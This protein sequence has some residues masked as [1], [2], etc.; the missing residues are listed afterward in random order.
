MLLVVITSFKVISM[1]GSNMDL[2]S[3]LH[4]LNHYG[5]T[6]K[7]GAFVWTKLVVYQLSVVQLPKHIQKIH[8]YTIDIFG[9]AE[10][11]SAEP[12][13]DLFKEIERHIQLKLANVQ[14]RQVYLYEFIKEIYKLTE[15]DKSKLSIIY[16]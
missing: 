10:N 16:K 7:D 1:E 13:S 14:L 12:C 9:E 2:D 5:D 4:F 8:D 6:G 15:F 11:T 3:I